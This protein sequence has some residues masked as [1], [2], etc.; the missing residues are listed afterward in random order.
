MPVREKQQNCNVNLH[1]S[2]FTIASPSKVWITEP[3]ETKRANGAT[4]GE[5]VFYPLGS[6]CEA[7]SVVLFV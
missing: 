6:L 5:Q 2:C 3:A 7:V 4:K 1:R